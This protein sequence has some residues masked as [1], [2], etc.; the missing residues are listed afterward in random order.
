MAVKLLF[1][2]NGAYEDIARAEALA[3][4]E[5]YGSTPSIEY[6]APQLLRVCCAAPPHGALERLALSHYALDYLCSVEP[7]QGALSGEAMSKIPSGTFSVRIK[8]VDKDLNS[9]HEERR[10]SEQILASTDTTVDLSAPSTQIIGIY[11][12]GLVHLGIVLSQSDAKEYNRRKPQYRPYF[13]P[14]SIDPRIARAI[15]NLSG[16]TKEVLDP[17]C[18]TG[19]ILIEA[20][21]MGLAVYGIDIEEKMVSGTILNLEHYHIA[22]AVRLGDATAIGSSFPRTF[23]SIVTDVPY[24]KSTVIGGGKDDLYRRAFLQMREHCDGRLV[25]VLPAEHDFSA[26]GFRTCSHYSYRV[27][28]SLRRHI[29]VLT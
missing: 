26:Y 20:G 9:M 12:G 8:K 18:G 25:V 1:F 3:V 17:F 22:G 2:L 6:E 16:A 23:H 27:H 10:L 15:V 21:L 19:G 5:A 11:V 29:Y 4:L 28:K 13:H 7:L 14:S 24:G